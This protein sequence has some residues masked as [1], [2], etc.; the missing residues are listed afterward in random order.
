MEVAT[1][2]VM[3]VDTAGVMAVATAMARVSFGDK[4]SLGV[5][6]EPVGREKGFFGQVHCLN[7]PA[8]STS[9]IE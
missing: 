4:A 7:S 3:P 2:V 6:S 1:G 5:Q 8:L 9:R